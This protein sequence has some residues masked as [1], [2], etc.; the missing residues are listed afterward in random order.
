VRLQKYLA[1]A[2]VASRRHAE[3]MIAGGQVSVN[4]RV[5]RE[6]GTL[7][8]DSAEVLV[9]GRPVAAPADFRYVVINKPIRMVTTMSDPEGRRTV[10]SLVDSQPRVVPV[11]RLDYDTSGVLLMT[12]D[13]DLAHVLTH[14]SYGVEKTYRAVVRGRLDRQ[15]VDSL[16]AGVRLA[17]G[18][19]APAKVRVVSSS[20]QRS[21]IDL[22]IH[23]GRNR[24]VRRMLESLGHPIVSLT[25]LRFG[26]IAL[27][28]L[29]AGASRPAT[30]REVRALRAAADV[31]KAGRP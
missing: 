29:A 12:N 11:G 21:E 1:R 7:V 4:G 27:G 22:T 24:Q 25:R 10:A 8:D 26:P 23:E 31:A 13:G 20:A 3:E 15:A 16:L 14:P 2:G 28:T 30:D 6:M 18:E 17:E 9:A 19:T 5:V